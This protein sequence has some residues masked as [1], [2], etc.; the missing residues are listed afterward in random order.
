MSSIGQV[1]QASPGKAVPHELCCFAA[2]NQAHLQ[3]NNF[4]MEVLS[5]HSGVA[6]RISCGFVDA[7]RSLKLHFFFWNR[8]VRPLQTHATTFHECGVKLGWD[9]K[10]KLETPVDFEQ[11]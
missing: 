2:P 1:C 10:R 4:D 5:Y 7:N 3:S 11:R 8:R 6:P 9:S